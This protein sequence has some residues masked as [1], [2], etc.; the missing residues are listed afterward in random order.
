M[1]QVL[2]SAY[3]T[4]RLRSLVGCLSNSKGKKN[5]FSSTKCNCIK[6]SLK[7]STSEEAKP[8]SYRKKGGTLDKLKVL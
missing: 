7:Y 3:Q 1:K 2:K 8:L 5:K 6:I 4:D